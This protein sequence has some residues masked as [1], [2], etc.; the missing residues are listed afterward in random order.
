MSVPP[1]PVSKSMADITNQS[2]TH[3]PSPGVASAPFLDL[4][5]KQ[6][7]TETCLPSFA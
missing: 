1:L 3:P 5:S 6:P 4:G 7:M 2:Q